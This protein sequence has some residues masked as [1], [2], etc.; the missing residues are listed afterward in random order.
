MY[1]RYVSCRLENRISGKPTTDSQQKTPE[2]DEDANTTTE[3]NAALTFVDPGTEVAATCCTNGRAADDT[4][5]ADDERIYHIARSLL[6]I[7][8]SIDPQFLRQPFGPSTKRKD[9]TV[10]RAEQEAGRRALLRWQVSLMNATSCSQVF[11]HQML[12]EDSILWRRSTLNA[13]CK[14][15]RRRGNP[16]K[17]LLC[18]GCNA[19]KHLFCCKP[20]LTVS[21]WF[22]RS[23]ENRIEEN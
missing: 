19:G 4:A 11:L 9:A 22:S 16:E 18:D 21:R 8:Q 1:K 14:V 13:V 17:M 7:A 10:V 15:C 3:S 12:L 20:M 23:V 6:Q 5:A 2:E